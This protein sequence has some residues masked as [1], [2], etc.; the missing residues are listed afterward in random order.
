MCMCVNVCV[1]GLVGVPWGCPAWRSARACDPSIRE[2]A[3]AGVEEMNG[4]IFLVEASGCWQVELRDE[5]A[6]TLV[7]GY[8]WVEAG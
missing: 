1:N 7:S 8:A 4:W 2:L 5:V 3:E 6:R